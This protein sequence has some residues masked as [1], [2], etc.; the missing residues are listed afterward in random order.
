MYVLTS[1]DINVNCKYPEVYTYLYKDA[2]KAKLAFINKLEII[3]HSKC[4][5][6]GWQDDNNNS[7]S[8]CK[9]NGFFEYGGYSVLLD[10]VK[11]Q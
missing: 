3:T 1:A 5:E 6:D 4:Y 7:L 10:D 2:R 11:I 9:D 8:E